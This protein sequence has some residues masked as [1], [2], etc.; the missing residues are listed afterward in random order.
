VES[1]LVDSTPAHSAVRAR[2]QAQA[3]RDGRDPNL[4][5]QRLD[6]IRK[7]ALVAAT[8]VRR[9]TVVQTQVLKEALGQALERSNPVLENERLS[10]LADHWWVQ[11][12]VGN[13][14]IDLDPTRPDA[15]P[16]QTVAQPARTSAI[17]NL[18]DELYH[19]VRIRAVVEGIVDG[20]LNEHPVIDH[21]VRVADVVAKRIT[22]TQGPSGGT[23]NPA[24]GGEAAWVKTNVLSPTAWTPVLQ[25]GSDQI[26]QSTFTTSGDVRQAGGD[27]GPT[28]G[29]HAAGGLVDAFGG[30]DATPTRLT[31]EFL[32]YEILVPGRPARTERRALFDWVGP[33]ARSAQ[34]A[35]SLAKLGSISAQQQIDLAQST[36]ILLIGAEPSREFVEY[37]TGLSLAR[38]SRAAERLARD[39][40]SLN[41][42]MAEGPNETP[43]PSLLSLALARHLWSRVAN[44]VQLVRP[45]ILTAHSCL[46]AGGPDSFQI[47]SSFDI[48]ANDVDVAAQDRNNDDAASIRLEQGVLDTN[49][50]AV[51][52]GAA[53]SPSNAAEN[54]T[55][56]AW[57]PVVARDASQLP[58]TLNA[59]LRARAAAELDRGFAAVVAG[60]PGVATTLTWWRVD[61]KTGTALGIGDRGWGQA[62]KEYQNAVRIFYKAVIMGIC[63]KT[64]VDAGRYVR[65]A[66]CVASGGL[67]M[68]GVAGAGPVAGAAF[69]GMGDIVSIGILLFGG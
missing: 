2:L 10:D 37:M 41:A 30:G 47:W 1:N 35:E 33:S 19:R 34:S 24:G 42:V 45:N 26:V 3:Q 15:K 7:A 29:F 22:F 28:G 43:I 51:V 38:A 48:V 23:D 66:G 68:A 55:T 20:R 40:S 53:V 36:D 54:M 58:A 12:K 56:P 63:L 39:P 52:G 32:E 21:V 25:I 44:R 16:G 67:G 60:Q 57:K 14:W 27:Q 65:A 17:S 46:R 50:E 4:I 6:E 64:Y 49:V 31:A 69:S 11:V 9:R 61:P 62:L 13:A 18:D 59:D 8:E 5:A